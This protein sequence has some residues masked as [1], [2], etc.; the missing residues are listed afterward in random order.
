[1]VLP[2]IFGLMILAIVIYIALR[3]LGNVVMGL[4][5]IALVFIASYLILGYGPDLQAI[6]FIGQ[7]LPK[8]PSTTGEAIAVI[9][10][11]FYSIAIL[12]VSRDSGGNLLITVANTGK[13]SVSGFKVFVDGQAA[14]ITNTPKDPLKS[15]EVTVIQLDW[16]KDYSDIVVHTDKTLARYKK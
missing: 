4:A 16:N 12:D 15:K 6:P 11:V 7:Y 5:L 9:R 13:L 8:L 1:M 3:V 10:D 14:G 2:L